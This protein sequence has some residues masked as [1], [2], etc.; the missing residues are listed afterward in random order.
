MADK[1]LERTAGHRGALLKRVSVLLAAFLAFSVSVMM[2][3]RVIGLASPWMLLLLFFCF[4]GLAKIAEPVYM[5]KLPKRVRGI[6][7]WELDRILSS[8][9]DGARGRL[10]EA[11]PRDEELQ[12]P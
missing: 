11:V 1:P 2:M 9:R 6:R 4:L 10:A 8:R 5:L 3:Q 7:A 12:A